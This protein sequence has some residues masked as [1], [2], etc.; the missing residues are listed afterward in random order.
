MRRYSGKLGVAYTDIVYVDDQQTTR[1]VFEKR[2]KRLEW[3]ASVA[4]FSSTIA[5]KEYVST[6]CMEK[7]RVIA[8]CCDLHLGHG[9]DGE[10]NVFTRWIKTHRHDWPAKVVTIICT[11]NQE[12]HLEE[13][14]DGVL[15]KQYSAKELADTLR[16]HLQEPHHWTSN[17][18]LED[19]H[20]TST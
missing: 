16:I 2:A 13:A 9:P 17:A 15:Y 20:M 7:G 1:M 5:A 18:L 14:C 19:M 4:M 10:G 8:V 12:V 11:G 6:I 3:D